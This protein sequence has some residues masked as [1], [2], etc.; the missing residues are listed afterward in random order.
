MVDVTLEAR[1]RYQAALTHRK[2]A[3]H[4]EERRKLTNALRGPHST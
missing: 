4:V 3:Q 2:I 1:R